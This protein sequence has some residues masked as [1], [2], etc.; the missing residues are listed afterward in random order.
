M[1]WLPRPSNDSPVDRIMMPLILAFFLVSA[2]VGFA[3]EP[4]VKDRYSQVL[5]K[6][7]TPRLAPS[8]WKIIEAGKNKSQ[9]QLTGKLSIKV[10]SG[11]I[12]AIAV[13]ESTGFTAADDQIAAW[14]RARW[15][16]RPN[17]TQS[18][19]LPFT[20]IPPA[21][22]EAQPPPKLREVDLAGLKN[23]ETR[24]LIL[25]MELDHGQ[26]TKV[27]I[28]HST[29]DP[30]LDS[31]ATRWINDNWVFDPDKTGSFQMPIVFSKAKR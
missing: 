19:S 8:T 12:K 23:G 5:L 9:K 31:A 3:A 13:L 21:T 27:S 24:E 4:A 10:Q 14:I 26:I 7:P 18:F 17:I 25:S 15:Q 30:A 16:F 22:L 6:H 28:L 20:V 29:G 1:N 2:T 11:I